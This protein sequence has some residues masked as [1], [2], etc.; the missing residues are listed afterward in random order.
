[1]VIG[2]QLKNSAMRELCNIFVHDSRSVSN[3]ICEMLSNKHSMHTQLAMDHSG[4]SID[5]M[6]QKIIKIPHIITF[7]RIYFSTAIYFRP[8]CFLSYCAHIRYQVIGRN[9]II[10][11]FIIKLRPS[12]KHVRNESKFFLMLL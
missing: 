7:H 11:D 3:I 4:F 9:L 8:L 12:F 1:M 6:Q 5:E 10:W 2:M